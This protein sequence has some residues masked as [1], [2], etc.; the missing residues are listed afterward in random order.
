M[1]L[2]KNGKI[3]RS[4]GTRSKQIVNED[5]DNDFSKVLQFLVFGL[6]MYS[7]Y[8]KDGTLDSFN[9][10][11]MNNIREY[12]MFFENKRKTILIHMKS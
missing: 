4:F 6:P 7:Q 1:K 2:T 11:D 8:S 12:N 9:S 5:L 10:I 3:K